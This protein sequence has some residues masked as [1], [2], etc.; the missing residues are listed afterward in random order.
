MPISDTSIYFIIA[1]LGLAYPISLNAITRLDDKYKS[2]IIV[3]LFQRNF[4]FRAFQVLLFT[5]L[6]CITLQ[7]LWII[8]YK[9]IPPEHPKFFFHDWVDISLAVVTALLLAAFF[10]FTHRIFQFYVPLRL[11]VLLRKRK[12]D[13]NRLGFQALTALLFSGID[14]SDDKLVKTVANHFSQLFK[15]YRLDKGDEPVEYPVEFYELVYDTIFRSSKTDYWKV[16]NVGF[17]AASGGWLIG[18][19]EYT[20]ISDLTYAWLWNNL[21]LMIE[22]KRDDFIEAFWENSHQMITSGLSYIPERLDLE[23]PLNVLN[24]EDVNKREKER[25]QFFEFHTAIGGMLIYCKRYSVIKRLFNHTTSIPVRYELLP[26]TMNQVLDLFFR[27]W[28]SDGFFYIGK[29]QFP[30]A[31]GIQG[32]FTSKEYMARYTALL[33]IRQYFLVSQWYGYEPVSPPQGPNSQDERSRWIQNLPYFKRFVGEI[34]D[35]KTLLD[36]LGYEK[37]TPEWAEEHHKTEPSLMID[38]LIHRIEAEYKEA[39]QNQE[40]EAAKKQAFRTAAGAI[41]DGR[42][43]SFN[44]VLNQAAIDEAYNSTVIQGGYILYKKAAFGADQDTTY[45]NYDTFFAQEIGAS[46]VRHI[47]AM[48]RSKVTRTYLFRAKELFEGIDKLHLN[49]NTHVLLN[50]GLA[51]D[52]VASQ[53]GIERLTPQLY[54]GISIITIA[55]FDRSIISSSLIAIKRSDLP[56]FLFTAPTQA[57]INRF[58]LQLVSQQRQ[59]YAGIT[60]LNQNQELRSLFPNEN[61]DTL[62][63]SVVL[64]IEFKFEIRW[65]NN[66]KLARFALYSDFYQQGTVNDLSEVT[67]L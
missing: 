51:L 32:E 23:N 36:E 15:Q 50:F 47:T 6:F 26:M 60:D 24:A 5:S 56:R 53:N 45:L 42:V 41:I 61:D 43:N 28:T 22:I 62:N 2:S 1:I 65:R 7:F 3:E 66:A 40:V 64:S 16:R 35:N 46:I 55:Q 29:Y 4:A 27:F 67:K 14:L 37:I 54:K 58:N 44:N 38:Q 39:E 11:A 49:P 18:S 31:D 20:H 19:H 63:K 59:I 12:D 8:N 25:L 33:F 34:Q 9:P 30:G 21:K 57:D 17:R 10:L 13:Q 52:V 48:F